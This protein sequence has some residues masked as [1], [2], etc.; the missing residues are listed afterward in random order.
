M[1]EAHLGLY[2]LEL[3][4]AIST[5]HSDE[6]LHTAGALAGEGLC[7]LL[8]HVGDTAAA[9]AACSAASQASPGA[10]WAWR[11]L[12]F[13][14]LA[15]GEPEPAITAFQTALRG[16]PRHARTWEGLG[17]AYQ[18]LGRLTAAL[19]ARSAVPLMC[20]HHLAAKPVSL[21]CVRLAS[22]GEA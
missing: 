4:I 5:R 10:V 18:A 12:G 9:L 3:L 14:R 19:K 2:G 13:L 8:L 21:S 20:R 1:A 22:A 17:A 7:A 6:L 15:I 16:G 11:R